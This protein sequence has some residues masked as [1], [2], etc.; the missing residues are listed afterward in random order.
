[1]LTNLTDCQKLWREIQISTKYNLSLSNSTIAAK[2][3]FKNPESVSPCLS[4]QIILKDRTNRQSNKENDYFGID[5]Q[6]PMFK[7]LNNL[8][9]VFNSRQADEDHDMSKESSTEL[10][11][12]SDKMRYP[13]YD[14]YG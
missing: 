4:P 5:T 2:N 12:F 7:S 6:I 8:S 13:I 11:K 10:Q 9:S 1:M 3:K 14:N